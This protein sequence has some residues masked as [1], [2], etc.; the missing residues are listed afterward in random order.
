ME[1]SGHVLLGEEVAPFDVR[2]FVVQAVLLAEL[3]RQVK[4]HPLVLDLLQG[5]DRRLDL[6]DHLGHTGELPVPVGPRRGGL[7]L[8]QVGRVV[9]GVVVEQPLDIPAG[10]DQP[11][12]QR[13]GRG[14]ERG[15]QD[16]A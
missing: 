2:H 9:A 1:T 16:Q 7:R 14:R 15:R 10:H 11:F 5:D 6:G 4:Q 3:A 8:G 12:R 13:I